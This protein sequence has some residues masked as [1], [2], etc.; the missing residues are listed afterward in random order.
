MKAG[1]GW[2]SLYPMSHASS[3]SSSSSSRPAAACGRL[4]GDA[5]HGAIW[6]L[7]LDM[8]NDFM[9]TDEKLS[10]ALAFLLAHG[11]RGDR[12]LA[13]TLEETLKSPFVEDGVKLD[14]IAAFVL[15]SPAADGPQGPAFA[16]GPALADDESL[17]LAIHIDLN[18]TEAPQSDPNIPLSRKLELLE[19]S[20]L[21]ARV[22]PVQP[23]PVKGGWV[24]A[25]VDIDGALFDPV[26]RGASGAGHGNL[27][28]YLSA[29]GGSL[30]G[31]VA[32]KAELAPTA[33]DL[34]SVMAR[35][36]AEAGL[37]PRPS[38][39]FSGA[40]CEADTEVF[41]AM[42]LKNRPVVVASREAGTVLRY[43]TPEADRA[44]RPTVFVGL[45][46]RHFVQLVRR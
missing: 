25:A 4:G 7:A 16:G 10:S 17:A 46:G 42:A 12:A 24:G 43:S 32:L 27:C 33:T 45:V 29:S 35:N 31:A 19:E 20:S 15:S 38:V 30:A 36:A 5:L 44:G 41:L 37:P 34:S 1:E 40:A 14:S 6:Q 9:T 3:L 21:T 28:F 11:A 13:A 23:A 26:D 39:D 8:Q 2:V 18:P 22:L